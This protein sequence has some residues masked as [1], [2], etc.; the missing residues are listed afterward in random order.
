MINLS[1]NTE[2]YDKTGASYSLLLAVLLLLLS[3]YTAPLIAHPAFNIRRGL[4]ALQKGDLAAAETELQRARFAEPDNPV[5]SY[6]L[7]VVSYR[8]RDYQKAA[9]FF[10]ASAASGKDEQMKF[11][12]LY[13]LGN[14]AF[15]AGDYAAAVSAYSGSVEVKDDVHARYNLEVA[16]KK[17]QEQ[18]EKQ[19][20]DQ[21]Q[22]DQQQKKNDEKQQQDGQQN[23]NDQQ[24]GDE[25]EQPGD[26]PQNDQQSDSQKNKDKESG[27]DQ[28]KDA[29]ENGQDQ[30][31][32]DAKEQKQGE[33]SDQQKSENQ[34]GGS[35]DEN[36]SQ[37]QQLKEQAAADPSEKREDVEM[38]GSEEQK[39]EAAKPEASQRAR[40]L[41]NVKLNPYQV[42]RLLQQMQER[43]RQAQLHYRNET[44]RT[45]EADPFTMDAEQLQEW[46]QNRGRPRQQPSG[47]EPDW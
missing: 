15:K 29:G 28:Q 46:M 23:K 21:Q 30:Q 43:E 8:C 20:E 39:Q 42:E 45:D 41:K 37:T 1:K 3:G 47:D 44:Q 2:I 25:S 16:R 26:K 7:G 36:A 18:Q 33:E 9:S 19:Q 17:L 40:A 6:N 27:S 13:N 34:T 35:E 10:M 38:G 4:E 12:S 24:S 32:S 22:K 5:I 31:Q 14:S 11:D